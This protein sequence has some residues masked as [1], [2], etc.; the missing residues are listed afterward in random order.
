[1]ANATVNVVHPTERVDAS[2]ASLADIAS[3]RVEMKARAA[4]NWSPLGGARL[5]SDTTANV[6]NL[7]TGTY[8]FRA[9]WTDKDGQDSAPAET[10]YVVGPPAKLKPGVISVLPA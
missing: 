9:I 8:D 2:P 7:T 10:E 1:M 4:S 6:Q 5:P 3:W